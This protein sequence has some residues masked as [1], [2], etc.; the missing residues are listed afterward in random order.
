[1]DRDESQ[2]PFED[3]VELEDEDLVCASGGAGPLVE[4]PGE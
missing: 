4:R 1:M 2:A 3:L